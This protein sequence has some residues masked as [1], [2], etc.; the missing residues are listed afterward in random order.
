VHHLFGTTAFQEATIPLATATWL[1][2]KPLP[3]VYRH[4]P[5]VAVS[6]STKDDLV[7]RGFEARTIDVIPNGV[8]VEFYSP[9][10]KFSKSPTPLVLY[11]GRLKRYKRVDLIVRA[12]ARVAQQTPL[13]RLIIAGQGDARPALEELVNELGLADR[14]EF[15]GFVSEDEKRNLFRRTW[16]HMLTSSKEGWGITNIEAAACGTPTIASNSPGLRD[17]V[18]DGVTGFLVPHADVDAL[19]TRLQEVI[20][21]TE[22]RN[23]LSTQALGFARR[24]TWDAASQ[25][26]ETFLVQ[27]SQGAGDR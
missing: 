19:A 27:A 26:M 9:D 23:R 10:P 7:R 1:L 3:R 6:E 4:V 13:A 12:F 14:V 21:N 18:E 5:T 20:D 25:R 11:L 17:S 8:D 15:A 22:L 16:V 2:E 24:F